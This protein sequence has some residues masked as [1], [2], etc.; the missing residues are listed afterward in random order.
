MEPP[1]PCT[2]R[3]PQ[4]QKEAEC[5]KLKPSSLHEKPCPCATNLLLAEKSLSLAKKSLPCRESL[6]LAKKSLPCRG[7]SLSLAK[8]KRVQF[9]IFP[10]QE[11]SRLPRIFSVPAEAKEQTNETVYA[12]DSPSKKLPRP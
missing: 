4:L 8:N 7:R 10:R 12:Q 9:K 5:C 11:P 2:G 6:S 3:A 1:P